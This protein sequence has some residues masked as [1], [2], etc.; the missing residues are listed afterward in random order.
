MPCLRRKVHD[1]PAGVERM[2]VRTHVRSFAS[3]PLPLASGVMS[4]PSTCRPSSLSL[5]CWGGTGCRVGRTPVHPNLCDVLVE[6]MFAEHMFV[7]RLF[8]EPL[9]FLVL[10]R[11]LVRSVDSHKCFSNKSTQR[12]DRYSAL[13]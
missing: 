12:L 7:E 2:F 9:A 10:I 11:T 4:S 8:G 5:G 13:L 3:C 1:S 6:H